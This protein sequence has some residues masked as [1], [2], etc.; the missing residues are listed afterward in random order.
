MGTAQRQKESL[1]TKTLP[2]GPRSALQRLRLASL[3][4]RAACRVPGLVFRGEEFGP[5]LEGT[6]SQT[7]SSALGCLLQEHEVL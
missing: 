3:E 5:S 6:H 4:K 1:L 7:G 2:K